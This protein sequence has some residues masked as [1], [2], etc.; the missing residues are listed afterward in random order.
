MIYSKTV[1]DCGVY[2]SEG[3]L[4]AMTFMNSDFACSLL[5]R[6]VRDKI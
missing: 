4:G 2:F 3:R 1:W 5:I 6:V